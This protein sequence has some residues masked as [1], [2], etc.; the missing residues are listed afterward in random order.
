[1][2]TEVSHHR[3]FKLL[4]SCCSCTYFCSLDANTATRQTRAPRPYPQHHLTFPSIQRITPSKQKPFLFLYKI[5]TYV[6]YEDLLG[7]IQELDL[8]MQHP[9]AGQAQ[10]PIAASG[11]QGREPP[12][13]AHTA[14]S[15]QLGAGL[16]AQMGRG[17]CSK[18][19]ECLRVG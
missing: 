18:G 1:M 14:S 8:Q 5:P 6:H 3:S 16:H 17:G 19:T 12:V 11:V 9:G 15:P 4:F 10:S 7:V 13:L 2:H